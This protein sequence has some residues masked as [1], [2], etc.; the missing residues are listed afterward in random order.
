MLERGDFRHAQKV[1]QRFPT[2]H[3]VLIVAQRAASDLPARLGLT[4]SRKVGTAVRRNQLKRLT[5][6]VF[7]RGYGHFPEGMDYV[8][9]FKPGTIALR[10]EDVV[11]S[12][13]KVLPRVRK[14]MR[15]SLPEAKGQ[16]QTASDEA[17][18]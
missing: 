3:F 2:D 18:R 11:Q 14:A 1:G 9:L 15:S 10:L 13:S 7:R 4:L 8:V 16:R 12:F 17:R 6:E 5:R